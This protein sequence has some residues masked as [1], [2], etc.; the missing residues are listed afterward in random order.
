MK[1]AD[2]TSALVQFSAGR[3]PAECCW[4][5]SKVVK[6]FIEECKNGGYSHEVLNRELGPEN[7]TLQSATIRISGFRINNFINTWIGTIQWVGKSTYRNYKKRNNWFIGVFQLNIPSEII[8]NMN[9]VKFKAMRSSGPG[10]QHVN[11]V[12]SA[13]RATHIPTGTNVVVMESRSQHQN[14]KLATIRLTEKLKEVHTVALKKHMEHQWE[15]HM[16]LHRGNPI[17]IF[18]ESNFKQEKKEKTH[19]SARQQVK[20]YLKKKLWD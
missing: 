6:M 8:I 15:N 20:K 10:G 18:K 2:N 11:K 16:N 1:N 9:D 17:R 19:K 3:G 5:V 12:S 14:K 13:I 7:G 4:V